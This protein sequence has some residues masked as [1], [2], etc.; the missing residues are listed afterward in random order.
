MKFFMEAYGC[1]MNQGEARM[2]AEL[3]EECGW[4]QTS[5]VEQADLLVLATCTVIETTERKM[6]KRLRS[7][8]SH[9][10]PLLVA[11]CMAEVQKE[12]V[13]SIAPQSEF[14]D[15]HNIPND[16]E[17]LR[18]KYPSSR[19][20]EDSTE[21]KGVR[22]IEGIVPIAQGC[23]AHCSYCIAK[24]ARGDLTSYPIARILDHIEK[25]LG[26]G[27]REIRLTAMDTASY[28]QDLDINLSELINNVC[29]IEGDFRVRVGMAN[30]K[31]VRPILEDLIDAYDD[32]KVFKF[33]HLP[34]QSGNDNVLSR[35]NRG[36]SVED[37]NHI[38]KAFRNDFKDLLLSTD[39]I[40]GFP[41]EDEE[42]FLDSLELVKKVR[43]DIVNITRF[44]PRS[45]TKAQR[46]KDQIVGWKVKERSRRLNSFRGEISRK[47]NERFI[48][49][50]EEVLTVEYGKNNATI[51]RTGAYRP[52]VIFDKLHLGE[53]LD[54]RI[55]DNGETYLIGEKT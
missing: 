18:A 32:E 5:S 21:M 48:G 3:M 39:I 46:M 13:K 20:P 45:G 55:V 35:M 24:L 23:S 22:R 27:A 54:V 40:V 10:K 9:N 31:S 44:S 47:N 53:F 52:V 14:I 26:K 8:V 49:R 2:I 30:P 36:Y 25:E 7:M 29:R 1:T 15:L 6:L 51:G 38:V 37:F 50:K 19:L 43:P 41:G 17:E 4:A 33:L 16:L 12:V 28:G 42:E 11:G 34:V